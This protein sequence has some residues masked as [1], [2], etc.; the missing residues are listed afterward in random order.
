MAWQNRIAEV[1]RKSSEMRQLQARTSAE[2]KAMIPAIL[3]KAF[4]GKL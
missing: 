1:D 2:L 4:A 3:D